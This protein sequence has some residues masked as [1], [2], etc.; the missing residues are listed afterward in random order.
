MRSVLALVALGARLAIPASEPVTRGVARHSGA[1]RLALAL[2][3][4]HL[5]V[6]CVAQRVV[7]R[8]GSQAPSPTTAIS[9][10]SA[11]EALFPV[12]P[13]LAASP[14]P[15]AP[16]AIATCFECNDGRLRLEAGWR[17][18][19]SAKLKVGGKALSQAGYADS[20]WYAT[21]VPSTVLA[22]LVKD[23]VY[24][25][26]YLANHFDSIPSAPF[27][28]SYWYRTEFGL[29]ADGETQATWLSLDGINYRA[30]V[31][32]NGVLIAS[33][34]QLV[35]TF[36]GR[37]LDVSTAL[38]RGQ[39]NALAIEVFPPDLKHDLALSWLD[40]NPTPADRNMGIWRDVYLKTSGPVTVR[41][42]HV[43][44][45]L[46]LSRLDSAELTFKTELRNTTERA[47]HVAVE[48]RFVP[49]S[50]AAAGAP[51]VVSQDVELTPGETRTVTFE[52]SRYPSLL[53]QNPH[54]WWPK[55]LGQANQYDLSIQAEVLGR[56][57]DLQ[58][59]RFGIRDVSFEQNPTGERVFRING[60]RVM[61]RGGG[62]ASDM[63]LRSSDARL[64]TELSLVKDL[65]LNTIRLE[66]KLESDDFYAKADA[67]GLLVMPGWMC[68]DRWQ[69]SKSWSRAEHELA[70]ASTRSQARR[71][72]NH[73]SVIDFLIGSDE[74]PA[75]AVERELV[76]EL[77]KQDWSVA[78][79][80]AAS[81]RTTAL[82]GKSGLKMS[83][84]YDWVSPL[85]WYED[86]E[87][88]G[89]FGFNAETSPGPAIPELETLKEWLAPDELDSLWSKPRARLLHAGTR[90]TRFE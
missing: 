75:P 67:A 57:S 72:R 3:L 87:H 27:A 63:L 12:L 21:S 29:P 53:L 49:A 28:G 64:E 79:S 77:R 7:R 32:L 34:Q 48:A 8:T 9:S 71:L 59:V 24:P 82:L 84:P 45:K 22:A 58:P 39:V 6:A 41:G 19:A 31:W 51:V 88:G 20:D 17:L 25:D 36:I 47:L 14:K 2:A 11:P 55:Q 52:P 61:I 40:W 35:G 15:E 43:L 83:G 56:V 81:D 90:G 30:N 69:E 33:S 66:G 78:I 70:I 23:G 65:G 44:S 13:E 76:A 37:E 86:H 1:R 54:L 85:Y 68:C 60:K 18:Q 80:P 38:R 10:P 16:P 26:P 62:W 73:P 4:T 50:N 5:A 46:D 42:S 89:A 74:A